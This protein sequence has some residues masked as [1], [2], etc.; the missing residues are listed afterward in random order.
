MMCTL[1]VDS[2]SVSSFMTTKIVTDT[3]D[4]NISSV[5]KKMDGNNIGSVIIIDNER[6]KKA[7]GIITERDVVRII[8]KLQPWLLSTPLSALMSKPLITIRSNASLRDGIQTMYSKNI[9]RLPVISEDKEGEIVG[10][11]TDKD[12]FKMLMKNQNLV[13]SLLADNMMSHSMQT[14]H[15]QFAEYWFGDILIHRK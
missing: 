8:G 15:E 9:R 7:V 2:I 14:V 6:D 13:Q 1:S 5:S 3:Q 12:I 4:Q 10:I 11:I